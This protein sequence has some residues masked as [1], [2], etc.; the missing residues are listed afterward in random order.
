MPEK[1]ELSEPVIKVVTGPCPH[2]HKTTLVELTRKEFHTLVEGHLPASKVK[3]PGRD[4]AFMLFLETG[5][6]IPCPA[7][8]EGGNDEA[9]S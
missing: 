7:T 4:A 3:L 9:S 1:V 5:E 2:C 6:H 8:T